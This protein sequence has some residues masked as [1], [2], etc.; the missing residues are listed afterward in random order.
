MKQWAS[1]EIIRK[2]KVNEMVTKV[3][4]SE[5]WMNGWMDI[6]YQAHLNFLPPQISCND[7][8]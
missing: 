2:S 3:Y 4:S 1:R 7:P 6:K 8:E 5:G